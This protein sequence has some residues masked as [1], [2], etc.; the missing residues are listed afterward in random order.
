MDLTETVGRRP[1]GLYLLKILIITILCIGVFLLG[2]LFFL[3]LKREV[4]ILIVE[5]T[6]VLILLMA[7]YVIAISILPT[8][9]KKIILKLNQFFL[10]N[11]KVVIMEFGQTA[12]EFFNLILKC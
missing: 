6:L 8:P 1:W 7:G 3:L 11:I 4:V 12:K 9:I 10:K 2:K 5:F